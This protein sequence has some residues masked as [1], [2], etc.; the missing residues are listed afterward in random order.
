MKAAYGGESF[1]FGPDYIIPKPFDRRLLTFVAR[2]VGEAAVKTGDA[3]ITDITHFTEYLNALAFTQ[4][5]HFSSVTNAVRIVSFADHKILVT[6][7]QAAEKQCHIIE[8]GAE[9][10]GARLEDI[11]G[12]KVKLSFSDGKIVKVSPA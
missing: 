4:K 1:G 8:P 12:K 5:K 3:R 10:D 11:A 2:A 6:D 9:L 7:E